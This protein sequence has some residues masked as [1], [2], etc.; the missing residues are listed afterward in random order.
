LQHSTQV[1]LQVSQGGN[2]P[3]QQHITLTLGPISKA[4]NNNPSSRE[5]RYVLQ[6][7]TSIG[8]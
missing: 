4:N 6:H 8:L 1:G 5:T 3:A 2:F 7:S